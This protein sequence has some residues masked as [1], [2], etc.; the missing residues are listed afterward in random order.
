MKN[1]FPF[2]SFP[3]GWFRVAYSDELPP[4]KVMPL[5]YFGKDLVLFRTSDGKAQVWDAHCPHL[6]A[7]LGYGGKVE[8]DTI[9]CPFHGWSFNQDGTCAHIPYASKIPPKAQIRSWPVC[10]V[11]GLIAV[12]H[13]AQ[14][15]PPTGKMPEFPRWTKEGW[16]SFKRRRW[17][18]RT[19][20]Q[21]M[22]E[23]AM[24]TAHMLFLHKETFR[25][26]KDAS[27][28]IDGPVFIR[29]MFPKYH[30]PFAGKLGIEGEGFLEITC[31]GL[32]CQVGYSSMNLMGEFSALSIFL[33]TPID[34]EYLDVHFVFSMKK[35]FNPLATFALE[36]KTVAEVS[37][38]LEQDIPIW[39]NK[40]YR[41]HPLLSE[42]DGPILQYRRWVRQFYSEDLPAL[43]AEETPSPLPEKLRR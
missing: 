42:G 35:L 15:E 10:E 22:C 29:R 20:P 3:N 11:N 31:Y 1:R 21:E 23:N 6:G 25:A 43:A 34:R 9:Q 38:N 28:E 5:H 26:V 32:G 13:H 30:L 41:S 12:Y 37:A 27:S 4:K 16:T 36:K 14:G 40:V 2:S 24:D 18:I 19:H 39:E 33:L 7:H 17:K 8:G